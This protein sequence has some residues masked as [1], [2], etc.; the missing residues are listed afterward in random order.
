MQQNQKFVN[1]IINSQEEIPYMDANHGNF[2]YSQ[3]ANKMNLI[4]SNSNSKMNQNNINSSSQN[5]FN[6]NNMNTS[7]MNMNLNNSNPNQMQSIDLFMNNIIQN[8][9]NNNI[10]NIPH[11]NIQAVQKM[12]EV[13][14]DGNTS[15]QNSLPLNTNTNNPD[16]NNIG[17]VTNNFGNLV[18]AINTYNSRHINHNNN[19]VSTVNNLTG[20]LSK[21]F[22]D[23][24]KQN[25]GIDPNCDPEDKKDESK[26]LFFLNSIHIN[27]LK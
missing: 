12:L 4:P 18:E 7:N 26:N 17:N 8:I 23:Q 10:P 5:N 16:L 1:N 14:K 13:Q 2:M 9:T 25:L 3:M 27:K 19:I 20:V 15:L 21:S 22:A 6:M 24:D 11:S